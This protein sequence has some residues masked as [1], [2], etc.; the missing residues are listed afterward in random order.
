ML[1]IVINILAF[2]H[3]GLIV[4]VVPEVL[5]H[6]KRRTRRHKRWIV[7][8]FWDILCNFFNMM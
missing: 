2:Y 4:D 5:D 1:V 3:L 7:I 8:F 6:R